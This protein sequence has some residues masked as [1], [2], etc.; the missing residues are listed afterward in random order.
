MGAS[1]AE[2]LDRSRLIWIISIGKSVPVY[3]GLLGT[4]N[5]VSRKAS[6]MPLSK[7]YIL[8]S[9]LVLDVRSPWHPVSRYSVDDI[10]VL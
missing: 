4:D 2:D 1:P 7:Y 10:S 6:R 5:L 9:N 3:M 8:C